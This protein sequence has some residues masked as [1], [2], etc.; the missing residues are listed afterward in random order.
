MRLLLKLIFVVVP[1]AAVVGLLRMC[2]GGAA[3]RW[4]DRVSVIDSD[5]VL[6][7][8]RNEL[9]VVA[10]SRE[11]GVDVGEYALSFRRALATEYGELLGTDV[12]RAMV[13][14]VFSHVEMVAAYA[15]QGAL[16]DRA[17]ME[18]ASGYTD[19]RRN[20]IFLPPE[21]GREVVRHELVHLLMNLET[22]SSVSFSPWLSEG[23]A[24][25]FEGF[26]PP[27][28]VAISMDQKAL[29]RMA[30]GKRGVDVTRLLELDVYRDFL[31]DDGA[32]NYLESQALVTFLMATEGRDKMQEL[33]RLER[34]ARTTGM[35]R[36]IEVY[37]EPE[38]VADAVRAWLRGR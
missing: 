21:V 33:I 10:P 35:Q 30:L 20:A 32:R 13:V 8:D 11:R 7:I 18:H 29:L 23:L 12:D 26:E 6:A 25:Y 5:A 1:I 3:D 37:G 9:I 34:N 36:F 17:A 38:R 24:Q 4:L 22:A 27:E 15:N 16:A 2:E 14:V 19:A 31:I 28:P